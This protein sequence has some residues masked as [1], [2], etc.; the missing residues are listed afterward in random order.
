M[1]TIAPAETILLAKDH[2][3]VKRSCFIDV[4]FT[5]GPCHSNYEGCIVGRVV[6]GQPGPVGVK[7]KEMFSSVSSKVCPQGST[8]GRPSYRA[9]H[10][11]HRESPILKA[12][13]RR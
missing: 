2:T 13:N 10:R 9:S 12:R 11:P 4:C 1:D 7:Q 5:I 3:F 6:G 8:T